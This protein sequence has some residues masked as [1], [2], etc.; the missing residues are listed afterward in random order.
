MSIDR[1]ALNR[2]RE[3]IGALVKAK[4]HEIE[5][6]FRDVVRVEPSPVFNFVSLAD[7]QKASAQDPRQFSFHHETRG[8][9]DTAQAAFDDWEAKL[10]IPHGEILY[11]RA[12]PEIDYSIDF[13]SGKAVWRVYSRYAV[14]KPAS[15]EENE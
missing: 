14:L 10:R 6:P 3:R 2:D 11:W 5:Q 7:M 15:P 9:G 13:A 12:E 1:Q 4:Q 8:N